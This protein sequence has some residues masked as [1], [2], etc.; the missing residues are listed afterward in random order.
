MNYYFWI[1]INFDVIGVEMGVVLKNIIVIGVGV[2]YGLGFG[3][4][5]KVVIMMCGLVEI[6]CLGVV[7]GVNLL[8]FIGLSGVGDL[9]V[10]CISVYFRNWC[11]GNLLG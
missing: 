9:V 10:I 1:Y 3:D 6:S 4:N 5:V 7:M 2:I 8:I 11:V